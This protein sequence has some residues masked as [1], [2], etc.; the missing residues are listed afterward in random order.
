LV[1]FELSASLPVFMAI[2][3]GE[4]L[5]GEADQEAEPTDGS[6]EAFIQVPMPP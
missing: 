4:S 2:P 3:E 1:D 6:A 5:I